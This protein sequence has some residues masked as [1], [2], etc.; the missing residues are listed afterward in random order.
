MVGECLFGAL[1]GDN[2][3][4]RGVQG[5]GTASLDCKGCS[6][7]IANVWSVMETDYEV[8]NQG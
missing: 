3:V 8:G 1:D 6:Y 7:S 4:F 2:G 5:H